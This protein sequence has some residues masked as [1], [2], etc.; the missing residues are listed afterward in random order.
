L[1]TASAA[2][3]WLGEFAPLLEACLA[4]A[5][6]ERD[7]E[8]SSRELT[9]WLTVELPRLWPGMPAWTWDLEIWGQEPGVR[10]GGE[11]LLAWGGLGKEVIAP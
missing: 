2:T 1:I 10:E 6:Q 11:A 4:T 7:L 9:R 3:A 5:D 8:P